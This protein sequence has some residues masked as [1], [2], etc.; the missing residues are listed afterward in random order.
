VK[1]DLRLIIFLILG[2]VIG[3]VLNQMLVG[4]GMPDWVT[5]TQSVGLNPPPPPERAYDY[6]PAYLDLAIFRVTFGFSL[7][8]SFCSVLG[9]ALALFLFKKL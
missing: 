4:L 3:S 7:E 2:A 1:N 5:R 8:L 9:L 6:Q